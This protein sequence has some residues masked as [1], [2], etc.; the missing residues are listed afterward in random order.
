MTDTPNASN[1]TND[2]DTSNQPGSIGAGVTESGIIV[3][4]D[5]SDTSYRALT[6]AARL[7]EALHV[8][9]EGIAAWSYST[10]MYD[11]YYPSSEWSPEKDARDVLDRAA[12]SVFGDRRPDWYS[13]ST[14]RG[15]PA[16]VL[17]SASA[18]AQMLVLGSRGHGGFVGLML[19]SVSGACAAH[20]RCPVLIVHPENDSVDRAHEKAHK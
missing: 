19:G 17:I 9:V 1:N 11:V 5:G 10:S 20:A 8:S 3:G 15:R 16:Q 2:P 14:R 4:I 13:S 6:Q 18:G 7:G 12:A